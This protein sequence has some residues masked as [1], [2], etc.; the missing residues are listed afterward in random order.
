MNRR[1]FFK[2][3][4]IGL[5]SVA[6]FPT[7]SALSTEPTKSIILKKD[8]E[9]WKQYFRDTTQEYD[10]DDM[11]KDVSTQEG[12]IR[13]GILTMKRYYEDTNVQ[14]VHYHTDTQIDRLPN[15]SGPYNI[16]HMRYKH[17]KTQSMPTTHIE[18][19][20]T[21]ILLEV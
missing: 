2:T 8:K 7:I 15:K 14:M 9:Y 16:F 11:I 19:T 1:D 5:A 12:M 18:I 10:T 13:S 4:G 20:S 3:S 21:T 6:V 17:D